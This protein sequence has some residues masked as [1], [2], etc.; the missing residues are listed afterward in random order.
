M[1]ATQATMLAR[2]GRYFILR[3]RFMEFEEMGQGT[4]IVVAGLDFRNG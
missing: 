1:A 4:G 2:T 3:V